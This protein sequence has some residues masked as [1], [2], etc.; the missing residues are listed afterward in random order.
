LNVE[1]ARRLLAPFNP[2]WHD[3]EWSQKDPL[4]RRVR[5]SILQK[6]PRLYYH[7]RWYLP[8]PAYY[9]V[10]TIR[11]PRLQLPNAHAEVRGLAGS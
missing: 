5:K 7:N 8:E 10:V 4:L 2:W 9:R 11:G 3:P 1:E 6:P